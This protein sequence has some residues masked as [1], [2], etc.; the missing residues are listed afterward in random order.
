MHVQSLW[1]YPVKSMQGES[2]EQLE[3]DVLGMAGDR[4]RAVVDAATG[5]SLSAKRYAA[6]LLCRA[7]T[8]EGQV[9]ITLPDGTEF[10]ADATSAAEALSVLVNRHVVIRM[11]HREHAVRH[12][13]PSQLPTGEGEPFIWEPGLEGF[14]DRAP[15]HLITTATLGEFSR[16]QPNSSFDVVRFRPNIVVETDETGFVENDWVG[17]DVRLGTVACHVLDTKPRCV[18]TTRPQGDLPRDSEVMKTIMQSNEG[19]GGIELRALEA[20]S[21]RHGDPVVLT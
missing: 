19:C 21:L 11:A 4:R 6:L 14:F 8:I 5:V 13:F 16:L 12:E 20:G 17:R 1:R 15:L 9:M 3:V 7:W 10:P 2:V 18:M